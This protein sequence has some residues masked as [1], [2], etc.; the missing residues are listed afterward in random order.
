MKKEYAKPVIMFEDFTLNTSIASGCEAK[1]NL[2]ARGSCG[3]IPDDRWNQGAI[4][5]DSS[6]GCAITP[7]EGKYDTLCYHVPNESYNLFNS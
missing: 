4:F 2:Q 6:T 5:I 1:T 3:W 7:P